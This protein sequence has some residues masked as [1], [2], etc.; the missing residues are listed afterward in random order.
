MERPTQPRTT[1][2]QVSSLLILPLFTALLGSY[3]TWSKNKAE[4]EAARL[5]CRTDLVDRISVHLKDEDPTITLALLGILECVDEE[6]ARLIKAAVGEPVPQEVLDAK[7]KQVSDAVR[8]AVRTEAASSVTET[9][10]EH[11]GWYAVIGSYKTERDAVRAARLA[12]E[13][14]G[15]ENKTIAVYLSQ[16]GCFALTLGGELS[17]SKSGDERVREAKEAGPDL[18]RSAYVRH[19]KGWRR[20]TEVRGADLE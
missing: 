18:F 1:L 14:E 13:L 7:T 3:Y 12:L 4:I 15:L 8:Q 10:G 5:A 16:N 11:W 2:V 17:G 19:G 6:G 9:P 20:V